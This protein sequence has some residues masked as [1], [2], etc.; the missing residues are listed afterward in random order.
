MRS[1]PFSRRHGFRSDN[2]PITVWNDAPE[3]FRYAILLIA[4]EDCNLS[5]SRLR[6]LSCKVLRT[7]PDG[8]N[9]SD[10]PIWNEVQN[11]VMQCE[12]YRVFD[13][14]EEIAGD[15]D[16]QGVV[17]RGVTRN[18]KEY[19]EEEASLLMAEYGIGWKLEGG[20]VQAR[21]E[22][23]Y[24]SILKLAEQSLNDSQ[25]PTALRELKEAIR[26]LSRRPI[27]D[28]SGSITH[29][30]A[31]LECVARDVTQSPKP[32]LGDLAKQHPNL[33]P[34]PLDIAVEKLWGYA[35]NNARH[36][37][38][39]NDPT[40]EEAMLVVG[41]SATLVNYLVHKIKVL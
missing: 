40:R 34:K 39:G 22:E 7:Q 36:G 3:N 6:E 26:D 32:T 20:I 5:P 9:W 41:I 38:E 27:P 25:K 30:M 35:S 18:A 13:I 2:P 29:A 1:E 16:R 28:I 21:G 23:G 10:I 37:L 12:W 15:L 8:N 14:I 19:F 11:L 31:A 24:E 17:V 33:F 4:K